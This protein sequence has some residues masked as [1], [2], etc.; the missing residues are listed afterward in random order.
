MKILCNIVDSIII[1][2]DIISLSKYMGG[3][4]CC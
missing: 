3:D 1:G 4:T 2:N